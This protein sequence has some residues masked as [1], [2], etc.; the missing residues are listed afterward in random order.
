LVA[1]LAKALTD[2]RTEASRPRPGNRSRLS[3]PTARDGAGGL[4]DA[5]RSG[6]GRFG[7]GLARLLGAGGGGEGTS[8]PGQPPPPHGDRWWPGLLLVA[9]VLVAAA[10]LGW[11]LWRRR[12]ARPGPGWDER[13]VRD[14]ER[15]GRRLGHAR[16]PSETVDRYAAS[17]AHVTDLPG[18]AAVGPSLSRSLFGPAPL[19]DDARLEVQATIRAVGRAQR[20][21]AWARRGRPSTP[22][23]PGG[24]PAAVR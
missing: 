2:Q 5:V 1:A 4:L 18:L 17:L 16:R 8:G 23:S 6:L 24:E 19:P 14:L 15:I 9:L 3:E 21:P 12:R 7:S 13:A 10:L 11:W 22:T 20:R